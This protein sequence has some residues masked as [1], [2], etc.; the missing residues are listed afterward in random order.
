MSA[1][2]SLFVADGA[3]AQ[4]LTTTPG[5]M[6]GFA[7]EG[8][9]AD[10]FG[11]LGVVPVLASDHLTLKSGGSYLLSFHASGSS[12]NAGA[13]VIEAVLNLDG[14]ELALGQGHCSAGFVQDVIQDMGF[15][16]VPIEVAEGDDVDVSVFLESSAGTN[17]T[18]VHASLTAV[19][20][21]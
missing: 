21:R 13:R 12:D 14:A 19:R 20:V 11:D 10:E 17:Y 5:L 6:T 1:F 2:G 9:A 8:H 7:T 16:N 18:P 15:S 4:A 3:A